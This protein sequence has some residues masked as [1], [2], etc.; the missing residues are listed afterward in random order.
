MYIKWTLN[1]IEILKELYPITKN[2]EISIILNKTISSITNKAKKLK[3]YKNKDFTKKLKSENTTGEKN[4]MYG[5]QG[6]N[7]GRQF[8][9]ETKNKIRISKIGTAELK[10]EKNPM[11]GKPSFW[12]G[13]KL[14]IDTINKISKTRKDNYAKLSEYEKDRRREAFINRMCKIS[15]KETLPERIIFKLLNDLNIGFL[16]QLKIG[17]YLC[18]FVIDNKIIEV[19]GDYW[20]ANPIKYSNNLNETQK[21]KY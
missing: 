8:S 20:H 7:K 21:K 17:F 6:Y 19:Q 5:K 18:D 9:D 14:P 13:K 2:E 1:D 16:S 15:K 10:G 3:I 12:K 11:Y 4:P